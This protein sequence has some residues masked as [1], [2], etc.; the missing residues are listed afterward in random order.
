MVLHEPGTGLVAEQRAT[1]KPGVGQVLI[2]V[3]AC[4]VCRTDLHIVDGELAEQKLP[5]VPGHEIVGEVV[6]HGEGTR[7]L[8]IGDR[9]G[10][11]WLAWTCGECRYCASGSENL[12]EFAR[13]TGYSVDGGYAEYAVADERY[14]FAIPDAYSEAAAAPLMCAGVIGFRSLVRAGEGERLGIYGFGAAAHIVAQIAKHQGRHVFAFTRP[15]DE[16]GQR[17]AR[18]LG[19]VW[20][21]DSK[22]G[23][24]EQL[25]SAI[26]F[27]PVG[28]LV[29]VALRAVRRG[30]TVVCGGIHMSDVPSFPYEL[31]W[32]ERILCSV[33]NVTRQD[34]SEFLALA[35]RV[36]VH[37][38]VTTFALRDAN[39][40]LSA[41][42]QGRLRGA[43]VLVPD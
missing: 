43:A 15:G 40:A 21:S 29:P 5:L 12:C 6:A 14:C 28:S 27:A 25:D 26:I 36:P 2:R 33:A 11:S 24:P 31:L 17:F 18:E 10:V 1:P 23:P 19:A 20:A 13:F 7:R 42:R 30:G 22:A 3:R 8:A 37:T 16:E 32:G 34:A 4:G 39:E 9:V 38:E 35:P 41:L